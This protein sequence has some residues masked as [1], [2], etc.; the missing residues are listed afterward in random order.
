M[1]SEFFQRALYIPTI[2]FEM[3]W[4]TKTFQQGNK[5]AVYLWK[6]HQAE[7]IQSIKKLQ[8]NKAI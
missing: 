8:N 4:W 1:Y 5:F 6:R 3:R 7:A 2:F